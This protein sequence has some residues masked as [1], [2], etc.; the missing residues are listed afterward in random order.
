M[1]VRK[2]FSRTIA[3]I[4]CVAI[5]S[6]Q[7][8]PP[9]VVEQTERSAGPAEYPLQIAAADSMPR[10]HAEVPNIPRDLDTRDLI[11]DPRLVVICWFVLGVFLFPLSASAELVLSICVVT[12]VAILVESWEPYS[13]QSWLEGELRKL[14]TNDILVRHAADY[15]TEK[16]GMDARNFQ[17]GDTISRVVHSSDQKDLSSADKLELAWR[18]LAYVARE[19]DECLQM[20]IE[21]R[22]LDS[23]GIVLAKWQYENEICETGLLI[24]ETRNVF[25]PDAVESIVDYLVLDRVSSPAN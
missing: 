18:E 13:R 3:I 11:G 15:I 22:K 12:Y 25:Y 17:Q 1:I 7:T 23:T 10:I 24:R 5:A 2:T 16:T 19:N 4:V 14:A 21:G 6:C 8:V 20:R 9:R